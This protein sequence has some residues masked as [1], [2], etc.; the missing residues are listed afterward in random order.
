FGM[1]YD[2]EVL[3]LTPFVPEAMKG[4]YVLRNYRYRNATLDITVSGY[5]NRI[6]S[7]KL[8]GKKVKVAEIPS[9]LAGK[10]RLEIKLANNHVGGTISK[11]EH[12]VSPAT[13]VVTRNGSSIQWEAVEGAVK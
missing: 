5:G 7:V 11:K 12:S 10:H 4:T 3:S 13:P 8:D 1:N 9:E 2:A 6:A